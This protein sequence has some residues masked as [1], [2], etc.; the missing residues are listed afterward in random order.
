MTSRRKDSIKNGEKGI[1]LVVKRPHKLAQKALCILQ[2]PLISLNYTQKNVLS[3][4]GT[5]MLAQANERPQTILSL[6]Q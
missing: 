3:Q 2:L 4:A 5:S 6:L 1:I